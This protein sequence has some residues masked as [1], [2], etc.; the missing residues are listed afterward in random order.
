M[1]QQPARIKPHGV[2]VRYLTD[3]HPARLL[4]HAVLVL[5]FLPVLSGLQ[6]WLAGS[7]WGLSESLHIAMQAW[8]GEGGIQIPRE[9]DRNP[10]RNIS[11]WIVRVLLRAASV[12]GFAL[13][14]W[15]AARLIA[16]A[17]RAGRPAQQ[18]RASAPAGTDRTDKP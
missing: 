15:A 9:T 8:D 10:I 17:L 13:P 5:I 14:V 3:T 11:V 7:H 2:L 16:D 18:D 4:I 12:I 6:M 1:T